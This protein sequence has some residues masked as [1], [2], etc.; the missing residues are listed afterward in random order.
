MADDCSRLWHLTD[1][2]LL[3]YF[4]ETYPQTDS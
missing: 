3:L 4:D 1:W 2:Y